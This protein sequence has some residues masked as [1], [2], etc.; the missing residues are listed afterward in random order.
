MSSALLIGRSVHGP[1]HVSRDADYLVLGSVFPSESKPTGWN[2]LG[3]D[4]LGRTVEQS[5]APV[6]A[7]GGM[8]LARVPAVAS[9]G[10]AGLAAI[11]L[12][13]DPLDAAAEP[14]AAM[15]E[16]VVAIRGE[17]RS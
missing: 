14:E 11:G 6:L 9:V 10:A 3:L 13:V 8:T 1:E 7:I 4:V 16:L 2:A 15:V 17:F 5:A 12:F